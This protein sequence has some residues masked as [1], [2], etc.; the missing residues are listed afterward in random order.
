MNTP[1]EMPSTPAKSFGYIRFSKEDQKKG[2]S[3]ERQ[4]ETIL[5]FSE[6]T[7][8]GRADVTSYRDLGVSA[9]RVLN[10]DKPER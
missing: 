4:I 6:K 3:L 9:F 5:A 2:R 1:N 7:G 10:A 8:P